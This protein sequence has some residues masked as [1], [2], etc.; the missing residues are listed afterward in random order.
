M[1]STKHATPYGANTSLKF[2]LGQLSKYLFIHLDSLNK[3][4]WVECETSQLCLCPSCML[5]LTR[6]KSWCCIRQQGKY[7]PVQGED[8]ESVGER[9]NPSRHW[10]KRAPGLESWVLAGQ[11][12]QGALETTVLKNPASHAVRRNVQGRACV[13]FDSTRKSFVG[14]GQL[15]SDQLRK[16][17]LWD[18]VTVC[19]WTNWCWK[20]K[21]LTYLLL[22]N[23]LNKK[24]IKF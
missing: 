11:G 17:W 7:S 9:K 2:P 1:L 16:N 6:Q 5:S 24:Y 8:R 22:I 15:C 14:L 23:E 10:H 18:W 3:E 4:S 13:S 19:G 20:G 12:S 21:I